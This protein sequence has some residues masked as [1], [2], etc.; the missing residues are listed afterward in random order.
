[1]TINHYKCDALDSDYQINLPI[2][3]GFQGFLFSFFL[4][5]MIYKLHLYIAKASA[6]ELVGM[7]SQFDLLHISVSTHLPT[8]STSKVQFRANFSV[9][10][11]QSVWM[12]CSFNMANCLLEAKITRPPP[13]PLEVR[14]QPKIAIAVVNLQVF[15]NGNQKDSVSC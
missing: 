9:T 10:V 1:M 5:S 13:L 2:I 14:K 7:Q 8:Q 11:L 3:T 6:F 12:V 15:T 4:H